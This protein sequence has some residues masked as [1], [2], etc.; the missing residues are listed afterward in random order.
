[1]RFHQPRDLNRVTLHSSCLS[2]RKWSRS[3]Q[4]LNSPRFL[5]IH[6][7]GLVESNFAPR[8]AVDERGN[9]MNLLLKGDGQVADPAFALPEPRLQLLHPRGRVADLLDER[10]AR[11]AKRRLA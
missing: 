8:Q 9:V 10:V 11:C 7:I 3:E 1:M 2:Q 5:D 4:K 6:R